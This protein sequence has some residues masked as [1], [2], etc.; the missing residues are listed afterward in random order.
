MVLDNDPMRQIENLVQIIEFVLYVALPIFILSTL[1]LISVVKKTDFDLV[2]NAVTNP[3]IPDLDLNFFTKLQDNY[4]QTEKSK[5]PAY[6]N[7]FSLYALIGGF[8][9]MFV[10][11]IT[12]ELFR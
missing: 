2:N 1:Y 3:I 6:A 12:Q 5:I 8:F 10:L 7:R 9:L 4:L 11:V